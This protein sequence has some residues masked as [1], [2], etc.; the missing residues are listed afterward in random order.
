MNQPALGIDIGGSGIKAGFV[1][2]DTGELLG[3][4]I[5]I[6]TPIP[7][8]PDAVAAAIKDL[9]QGL[10]WKGDKIGCGF[11][12]VIQDGVALTAAN[13]DKQWMYTNVEE[14]L[15]RY[16]GHKY[17]VIN[18]ADAA[19]MAERMYGCIKNEKG[20]ILML[21]L[22]TGI[23][24]A[25]FYDG[26]LIPNTEFG[27]LIYR[28]SIAEDW[29][30]NRARKDRMMEYD[31]WASELAEFLDYTILL[32][33]PRK[34]VLGGGVSFKFDEFARHFEQLRV[35]VI[36]AAMYNDAGIIGAAVAAYPELMA[37][38]V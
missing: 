23:G 27:H 31:T 8:T 9:I 34:I 11:P 4:R 2:L 36:N 12:S 13:I 21:T 18:D 17:Y 25:L 35:P 32:L 22:G 29:V 5:K 37:P 38:F 19:G 6:D 15:H 7:S 16:T 14:L 20:T 1:N 24:S 30:S 28:G 3:E 33:A 10:G 26:V